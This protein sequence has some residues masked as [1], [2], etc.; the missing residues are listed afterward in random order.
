MDGT[1]DGMSNAHTALAEEFEDAALQLAESCMA[2]ND[3][4]IDGLSEEYARL[5][6]A[7][8]LHDE[9]ALA[10]TL[11]WGESNLRALASSPPEHRQTLLEQGLPYQWIEYC[12]AWLRDPN[13]STLLVELR[14]RLRDPD[15]P[16]ALDDARLEALLTA[17]CASDGEANAKSS[18]EDAPD[19]E[20]SDG[21]YPL[22]WSEEVHPELLEAFFIE[23]PGQAERLAMLLRRIANDEADD[24]TRLTAARLAHTLKGASGVV[25][26]EALSHL[27]HL[28]EDILDYCGR[29]SPPEALR[30]DL[31]ETADCLEGLFDAL[32]GKAPPPADYPALVER[33][34]AWRERLAPSEE[35]MPTGTPERAP[36]ATPRRRRVEPMLQ[37]PVALIDRLLNLVDELATT[38]GRARVEVARLVDLDQLARQQDERSQTVLGEM[39][40]LIENRLGN[41]ARLTTPNGDDP[42]F[43]EL[44]LDR[45][46]AAHGVVNMLEESLADGRELAHDATDQL[47]LLDEILREQGRVREEIGATLLRT[48]LIAIRTLIPR[49]ER[50]VRETCRAT[51]KQALLIVEN[52]ELVL[53]TDII[54]SLAEPL[55][56][57]LRNAVD[58]GIETPSE[59]IAAGKAERGTIHLRCERIGNRVRLVLDDDGAGWDL[60][61]IR[62]R[63]TEQGLIDAATELDEEQTLALVLRPGF[64]TREQVSTISG[65]GIGMDIVKASIERLRGQ[66]RLRAL[67]EGGTRIEI[68]LPTTLV[69]VDALIVEVGGQPFAIPADGIER[70]VYIDDEHLRLA[71]WPEEIA[72]YYAT[73]E[74]WRYRLDENREAALEPLA[75]LLGMRWSE[76]TQPSGTTA[77]LV[78]TAGSRH[79]FC[80]DRVIH[81]RNILLK[82][83]EPYL[84]QVPGLTGACL[85]DAGDVAPV[86]DLGR[87]LAYRRGGFDPRALLATVT[88]LTTVEPRAEVLIV[89]DSL[90]NRKALSLM[91]EQLGYVPITAIDGLDA[92]DRVEDQPPALILTDLEMPRMNGIELTHVLRQMPLGAD[93]PIVMITSRSSRKHREQAREAGI[94]DYLTKPVDDVT[95]RECLDHWLGAPSEA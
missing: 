25:G 39:A 94:S 48:R 73:A 4:T 30:D 56:H 37:V 82:P 78:E 22:H 34:E 42:P 69:A 14:D 21:G 10:A 79:L 66:L 70:L 58:H 62:A 12:A 92:L 68:E 93:L 50:I 51:G 59:R 65:R 53:D 52:D 76:I 67:S 28:T 16:E 63:A 2:P 47:R 33:L 1:G 9:S 6:M 74:C 61:R 64:S 80:V 17:L 75:A 35:A 29:A 23:S 26:I 18:E 71:P 38:T 36:P 31:T 54:N 24:E 91:V 5:A 20:H 3:T 77:L 15:W 57:L 49:L 13:D 41:G 89:D 90:S 43:D 40:D 7:C 45:Y 88:P 55:L 60:E 81:P 8:E 11:R 32:Q 46:N 72:A 83:L 86:L 19:S 85:L 87:L 27:T 84:T 95:L 44:E